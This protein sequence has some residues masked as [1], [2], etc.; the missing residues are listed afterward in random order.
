MAPLLD[1][2]ECLAHSDPCVTLLD[3]VLVQ[4]CQLS[5]ARLRGWQSG[6]EVEGSAFHF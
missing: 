1:S 6:V 3:S 2:S 5:T 4:T